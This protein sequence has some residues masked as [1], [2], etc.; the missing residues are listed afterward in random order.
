MEETISKYIKSFRRSLGVLS[1]IVRFDL[2]FDLPFFQPSGFALWSVQLTE[3]VDLDHQ[4][5]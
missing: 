1:V 5:L 2:R 3:L 4:H